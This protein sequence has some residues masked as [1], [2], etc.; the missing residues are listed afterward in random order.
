MPE[1]FLRGIVPAIVTPFRPDERID[2]QAWQELIEIQLASGVHGL[3]VLGGQG[4]FF[5]LNEEEREVAA[6]FCAQTVDGRVPVYVN[7]GAVTTLEAVRL[8]QKAEGDGVDAVV[9]VTPYYVRPSEAELVDHYIEIC[10]SVRLPV[11]AYNIPERTGVSLTP[12]ILGRI[13]AIC[14][15]FAGL[16][17]SSGDLD[18]IAKYRSGGLEVFMGRDHL[19]LE[20]LKR[21]CAGAVTACANVAPRAFVQLYEAYH[22]GDMERAGRLQTLVEPL[23]AAFALGTFPAV[24]K[25]A[26]QLIG[27]RAGRCRRPVGPLAVEARYKLAEALEPLRAEGLL[28]APAR[29]AAN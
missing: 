22:G 15:N 17:D 27:L 26:M 11:F 3:F 25:E 8:A 4:E 6:R 12:E 19:I 13:A 10:H 21:G 1:G 28:A 20:G 5:A 24:V 2:Y 14:E 9:A 23:R 18:A 7:V 16:K 29:I